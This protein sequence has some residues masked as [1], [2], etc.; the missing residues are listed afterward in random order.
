MINL[1][2]LLSI[3]IATKNRIP[4]CIQVIETILKFP[5]QDF[6]LVVQDNSDSL[7]LFDYVK[8]ITDSRFVYNY[9]APPFSSIDNFNKVISLSKGQYSCLIGDDDGINSDIFKIVRCA[10]AN[11]IDSIVPSLKAIYWWPDATKN[12]KGKENYNGLLSIGHLSSNIEF[13]STDG[14][15]EKLMKSGGQDYMNLNLP[16]LYHSVVKTKYLHSIK[17]KTGSFVGGLSPDIYISVA[18]ASFIKKI[19]RI[20]YPIVIPGICIASTSADSATKTNISKLEDAPHFRDRGE[21]FWAKQVPKFYSG[22]NIWADSSIAS[23]TDM[24]QLKLV[25]KFSIIDLVIVLLNRHNDYSDVI[26]KHYFDSYNATSYLQRCYYL[27]ALKL[28]KS[29]YKFI[30]FSVRVIGKFKRS[31][32]LNN[33]KNKPEN[34]Q[35][36]LNISQATDKLNQHL[37]KNSLSVDLIIRKID[38][39]FNPL[40]RK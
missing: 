32:A 30:N 35:N 23:L 16:K 25:N 3:L 2:P 12:I 39:I 20:D 19:V 11:N 9:S 36:V 18:L 5:D 10:S 28:K 26:L 1:K 29:Q 34:I 4:Y 7:E 6:E 37:A 14:E 8:G 33:N 24:D 38:N 27:I 40:R 31:I 22:V 21:Y 17:E 13:L 15:V